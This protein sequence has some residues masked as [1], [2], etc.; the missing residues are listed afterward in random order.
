MEVDFT[1]ENHGSIW[2][3]TPLTER[4]R[5]FTA[6]DLNV[7]G[8]QWMGNSFGVDHSVAPQLVS[9]LIDEG[10]EVQE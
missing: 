8:W 7:E 1:V 6:T 3:F 10:F 4:A 2:M 5:N 9:A